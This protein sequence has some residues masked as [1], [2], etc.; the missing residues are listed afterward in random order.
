VTVEEHVPAA[1]LRVDDERLDDAHRRD[2]AADGAVFAGRAD[3]RG[4]LAGGEE[5][6]QG[7]HASLG[8]EG[9]THPA[10]H[11]PPPCLTCSA[12]DLDVR[13]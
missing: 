3:L 5:L 6:R 13:Q 4:D 10:A 11:P 2:R 8:L 1:R 7:K 9:G 12:N